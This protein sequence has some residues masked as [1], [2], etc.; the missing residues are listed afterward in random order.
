MSKPSRVANEPTS[1]NLR[2]SMMLSKSRTSAAHWSC[3]SANQA[4]MAAGS[5]RGSRDP[6]APPVGGANDR[7]SWSTQR[8][9]S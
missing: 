6:A 7:T 9:G 1:A 3:I 4:R 2:S 8:T 5:S